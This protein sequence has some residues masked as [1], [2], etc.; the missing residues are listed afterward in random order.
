M[1]KVSSAEDARTWAMLFDSVQSLAS[2]ALCLQQ[3]PAKLNDFRRT[4]SC[5]ERTA[6][7]VFSECC[8]RHQFG[9]NRNFP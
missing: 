9:L 1:L 5:F 7:S 2:L 3:K 4:A 8:L 6:G